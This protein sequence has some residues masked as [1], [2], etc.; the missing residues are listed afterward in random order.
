MQYLGRVEGE[1]SLKVY[2]AFRRVSS[3]SI[4]SFTGYRDFIQLGLKASVISLSKILSA[5]PWNF[6]DS[7]NTS[8]HAN[9]CPETR[10]CLFARSLASDPCPLTVTSVLKTA[11]FIPNSADEK[12]ATPALGFW[13][14]TCPLSSSFILSGDSFGLLYVPI[15]TSLSI[16]SQSAT[17]LGFHSDLD[18]LLRPRGIDLHSL[19]LF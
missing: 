3:A 12:G 14:I 2:L 15:P 8:Y 19:F 6:G 17:S 9:C 5:F 7:F 16:R 18:L 1:N 4:F 13:P 11:W 10:L